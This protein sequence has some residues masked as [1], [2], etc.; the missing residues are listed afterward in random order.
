M[1]NHLQLYYILSLIKSTNCLCKWWEK[2]STG[3]TED[4]NKAGKYTKKQIDEKS[5]YYNNGKDTVALLCKDVEEKAIRSVY[6]SQL[7]TTFTF[8][9][10]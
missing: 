3:Y 1:D 2:D 4:L 5:D 8:N 9:K 10:E 7:N 6:I